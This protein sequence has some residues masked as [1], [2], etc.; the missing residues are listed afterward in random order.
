V[1]RPPNAAPF[2]LHA[3]A[4]ETRLRE[5][6]RTMHNCL[7]SYGDR[8]RGKHRIVE[9]RQAGTVRYAIHIERGRI[10][11]FEAPGNRR[12]DP[13]D[14]PVIRRLLEAGG[15]LTATIW[16]VS[17]HG[18]GRSAPVPPGQL[19]FPAADARPARRTAG[20]SGADTAP[21][22][23][24]GRPATSVR[25]VVSTERGA[26]TPR[27]GRTARAPARARERVPGVSLQQLATEYLGP[28]AL[29]SPDW[30]EVA[31]AMWASGLLPRLPSPS[32]T[33]FERVV[34]DL[35]GRVAIGE[36]R[37]LPRRTPPTPEE[38]T[39]AHRRLLEGETA[40]VGWQRRRMAAVLEFPVRP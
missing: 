19:A 26:R 24:A 10:V 5:L 7:G 40:D 29:Q 37:E 9:V 33:A 17:D 2:T 32:Q 3:V 16:G 4:D 22:D 1:T 14:V 30:T 23:L 35:A 21:A 36:D 39:R 6:G 13:A 27:T 11:T 34:R 25:R 18:G 12:P 31:A 38:R 28:A 20:R 15:Y 8:L